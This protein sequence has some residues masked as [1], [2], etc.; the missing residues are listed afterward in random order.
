MINDLSSLLPPLSA[1]MLFPL[2]ENQGD[3]WLKSLVVSAGGKSGHHRARWWVTPTGR[4]VR[5]SA[6]EKIP[7]AARVSLAAG[8]GE[9][10]R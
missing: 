7:P 1:R 8:K 4:E 6:T 3:R 5:A 10:V 2:G 9:M